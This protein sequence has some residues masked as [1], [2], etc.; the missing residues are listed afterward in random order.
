MPGCSRDS[1]FRTARHDILCI[2]S[3]TVEDATSNISLIQ[4]LCN[5][6]KIVCLQETWLWTYDHQDFKHKMMGNHT[7][8]LLKSIDQ[9]M[10]HSTN[11]KDSEG[12]AAWQFY[13]SKISSFNR[14]K[15]VQCVLLYI[16]TLIVNEVNGVQ[17]R[18]ACDVY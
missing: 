17:D 5:T 4:H 13:T 3:A 11:C 6:H 1:S 2:V 7:T 9:Y 8:I 16:C 12:G 18:S 10:N 15:Q 14:L